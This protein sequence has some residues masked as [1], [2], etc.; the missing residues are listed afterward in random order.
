MND[1]KVSNRLSLTQNILHEP[2]KESD[3]SFSERLK[4]AIK[5]VDDK[6]HVA[7]DAMEQ[8]IRGKLGIHE[9]MLAIG[10]ADTSLRLLI[11][12]RAKVMAAYSEIMHM[13]F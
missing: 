8:V 11:Q 12:V 9:G 10:E 1:I 6:Q 4:G 7:D 2:K 5:E 3:V 13:Q